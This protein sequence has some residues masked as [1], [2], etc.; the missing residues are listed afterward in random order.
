MHAP[1][2]GPPARMFAPTTSAIVKGAIVP[3]EPLLGSM[4]VAYTTYIN[5]NVMTISSIR[6]C[7]TP[8]PIATLKPCGLCNWESQGITHD[9]FKI[10]KHI[11]FIW[12]LLYY[13][14]KCFVTFYF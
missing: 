3:I 12:Y 13:K 2:K 11:K 14:L 6:S 1:S 7:P 10:I 4:A 8:T 9:G 5:P